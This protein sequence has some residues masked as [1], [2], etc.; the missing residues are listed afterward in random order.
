MVE[1]RALRVVSLES[2]R[3]GDMAR[4][5]SKR[6]MEVLSAPSMQ[7]VPL[8]D[9]GEALRFGERLMA[10]ECDVLVLLTGVGLKALVGALT[11]RWPLAR[12]VEA[13]GATVRACRGP[14]P[15][16]A[17][18]E[19]GLDA[20]LVAP[21]PNTW[22]ELLGE[23]QGVELR[24]KRVFVQEYGRSNDALVAAL[25]ERGAEVGVVPVYAWA[26]PDDLEP[27]KRGVAA[28]CDG[29]ADVVVFT[30]ARQVDHVMEVARAMGREE[31]LRAALR[32][33]CVVA[34]V[35]PVTSDA[36]REAGLPVD[37]EPER[38]KMGHLVKALAEGGAEVLAGKRG[39]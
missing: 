21:E 38:P 12:V 29:D 32:A 14:K 24:G 35:G 31:A 28:L 1:Q 7:E 19:L 3:A 27:L 9:Q 4:L 30:S 18:R 10:G 6:G 15:K 26:L 13:L 36:L 8:G 39:G 37:V 5:L 11:T 34:S 20:S 22:E 23:L 16:A 17:L 33:R 2:R 25:R